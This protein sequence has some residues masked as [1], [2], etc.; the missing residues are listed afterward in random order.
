MAKRILAPSEMRRENGSTCE[1]FRRM[2]GVTRRMSQRDETKEGLNQ[3]RGA[4]LSW[5]WWRLTRRSPALVGNAEDR[6]IR[7]RQT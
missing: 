6:C 7:S 5:V 2:K 3:R 1:A 4:R